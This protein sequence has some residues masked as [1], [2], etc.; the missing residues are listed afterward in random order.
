M[1][2]G[3]PKIGVEVEAIGIKAVKSGFFDLATD[4][5]EP[6]LM[7]AG[8]ASK[9]EAAWVGFAGA[10]EGRIMGPLAGI[11]GGALGALIG[12]QKLGEGLAELGKEGAGN[13]ETLE[14]QFK[15]LLKSAALTTERVEELIDV[16]KETPFNQDG[17]IK[18][19]KTLQTLT[20]G[21][22]ATKDGMLLVGDAA[23]VAGEDMQGV[24]KWVG[25][26]YDQL[27]S[28]QPI[29]E[30]ANRLQEM[31]I[32]SGQT[33]RALEAMN[34]SGAGFADMWGLV[35]AELKKSEGAMKDLSQTLEGL[36]STYEDTADILS[37]EFAKGFLEGEKAAV[38]ST[39]KAL[40][41]LTPAA[42]FFGDILGTVSNSGKKF[43]G[44][45]LETATGVTGFTEVLKV[46]GLGIIAFLGALAIGGGAAVGKFAVSILSA[47]GSMTRLTAATGSATVAQGIQTSVA[48]K[49][50]AANT[51]LALTANAVAT[52]NIKA[53]LSSLKAAAAHTI[54]AVKTNAFAA[55]S[56]MLRGALTVLGTSIKFVTTLMKAFLVSLVTN[57]FF[58][59]AAALLAVG[60]VMIKFA[61]EAKR[62][63]KALADYADA[64]K[65]LVSN[66]QAQQRAIETSTDLMK[67]HTDVVNAL[68]KAKADLAE[69]E[70]NGTKA[71]QQEAQKR[72]ALLEDELESVSKYD[73]DKLALTEDEKQRMV[74]KAASDK[75]VKKEA[76][77][78]ARSLMN[79]EERVADIQREAEE[80]ARAKAKAEDEILAQELTQRAQQDAGADTS[81]A[82][83][84]ISTLEAKLEGLKKDRDAIDRNLNK[85]RGFFGD[86]EVEKMQSDLR[87]GE[88]TAK[89]SVSDQASGDIFLAREIGAKSLTAGARKAEV[90]A[91][92]QEIQQI[93][94]LEE[95]L[96][97]LYSSAFD[98]QQGIEIG[99]T[100]DS[101]IKRLETQIALR[102]QIRALNEQIRS[103]SGKDNSEKSAEE[104][105]AEARALDKKKRQ[106]QSLE[107]LADGA[108]VDLSSRAES[109]DQTNLQ[110]KKAE[111]QEDN[112][113]LK[114]EQLKNEARM[115][116]ILIERRGVDA[117]LEMERAIAGIKN[118]GLEATMKELD[119]EQKKLDVARE[120][121]KLTDEEFG[122]R[123]AVVEAKRE[124]SRIEAAKATVKAL[125]ET[126]LRQ[127]KLEEEA[128][129]R[130]GN[131]EAAAN[132]Q[133]KADAVTDIELKKDLV[134]QA[135]ELFD[136]EVARSGWVQARLAGERAERETRRQF[137]ERDKARNREGTRTG[138]AISIAELREQVLKSAGRTQEAKAERD[139]AD[140]LKDSELRKKT[141]QDLI[142]QGFSAEEAAKRADT[143]VGIS[144]AQRE[145][146][147]I[148]EMGDGKIIASS[149]AR[150][151]GGGAVAGTDPV[152]SRIDRSNELLKEIR[153]LTGNS[154]GNVI[155][156]ATQ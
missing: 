111:L 95:E 35:E 65:D 123:S 139:K 72:I 1:S 19:N 129:R 62:A 15:P 55:S 59:V 25:R 124:K 88:N 117:R 140:A 84:E 101:E 127:F 131:L 138:E 78:A 23:A 41:R 67:A 48:G 103:E 40:E 119:F 24:A 132:A 66:L 107:A 57:P 42:S 16:T 151:G 87:S 128:A 91:K 46:G 143:Q 98:N 82:L 63:R 156:I 125:N 77:S 13:L 69:A 96:A 118:E 114:A 105:D 43:K 49:L 45:L 89:Y 51:Q 149:L 83:S 108:S 154:E 104:I 14:T 11:S 22:L 136:S 93:G 68:T 7:I 147:R 116:G 122:S 120:R 44:F 79:P 34:D 3:N 5:A 8:G 50:S 126:R 142:S 73:R 21:A 9:A 54:A 32:M 26:M 76:R 12:I 102:K 27:R 17:V 155:T 74:D 109:L 145:L 64:S 121:G 106:L 2:E 85:N 146:D 36:Q 4:L 33:R 53:A 141:E 133:S 153:D 150:I 37:A 130:V 99:L 29:G 18:A 39:T 110:I 75:E 115:A 144:Q 47:T 56:I 97:A 148:A 70:R 134:K 81:V 52:G 6:L 94:K 71:M 10:I 113:P 137:E 38:D 60:A 61:N 80:I 135:K 112:D 152:A 31:G 30:A 20:Q 28:G 86:E 90:D 92:L 100:S 58:L